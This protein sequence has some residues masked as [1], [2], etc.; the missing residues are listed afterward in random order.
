MMIT[1]DDL[2]AAR[3]RLL[4]LADVVQAVFDE[5]DGKLDPPT[6]PAAPNIRYATHRY[7]ASGPI[8][9]NATFFDAQDWEGF[10]QAAWPLNVE[11]YLFASIIKRPGDERGWTQY[12]PPGFVTDVDLA[13]RTDNG[14]PVW[15][16]TNGGDYLLDLSN[17]GLRRKMVETHVARVIERGA[18]G[19]YADEVD[20]TWTWAWPDIPG[21][22]QFPTLDSWRAAQLS[23]YTEL[24]DALHVKGKK[25]WINLGADYDISNP[26][27]NALVKKVDGINIEFFVGRDGVKMNTAMGETVLQALRFIR[28]VEQQ[29]YG[30]A[31]HVHAST[32]DQTVVNY[33]F[34]AWLLATEF[35]GSFTASLDYNGAFLAPSRYFMEAASKLGNP[36]GNFVG[37]TSGALFRTFEHGHVVVNHTDR[38]IG[39]TPPRSARIELS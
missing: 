23:L 16:V 22:R 37:L 5:L 39:V 9:Q 32:S 1:P 31:V 26:W 8:P 14:N 34:G 21:I 28:S 7:L 20:Q 15:R 3:A 10:K 24:A 33:A 19:A 13:I 36:V 18:A 25:L 35:R 12:L 6:P 30:K 38:M 4:Q 11:R 17:P 27:Q 2:N 29:P